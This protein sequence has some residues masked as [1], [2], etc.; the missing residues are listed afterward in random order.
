MTQR[1]MLMA[2]YSPTLIR[3]E[4]RVKIRLSVYKNF[5]LNP[6]FATQNMN[7]AVDKRAVDN[8]IIIISTV[9]FHLLIMSKGKRKMSEINGRGSLLLKIARCLFDK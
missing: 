4:I 6:P 9:R 5:L 7:M 1:G 8:T 2:S 3:D